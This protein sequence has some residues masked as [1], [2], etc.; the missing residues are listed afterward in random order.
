ME[1]EEAK[2]LKGKHIRLILKNNFKFNGKVLDVN[3]GTLKLLDKFS[4]NVSID[5]NDIMVC[6][7]N[8]SDKE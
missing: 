5:L 7:L 6:T 3:N 2:K 4:E 1:E 8:G